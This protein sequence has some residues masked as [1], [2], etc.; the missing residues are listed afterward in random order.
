AIFLEFTMLALLAVTLFYT[1]EEERMDKMLKKMEDANRSQLDIL[2]GQQADIHQLSN[3]LVGQTSDIIKNRV[4][5]AISEYM[6]SDDQIKQVVAQ[7]IA[8]KILLGMRDTSSSGGSH[9]ARRR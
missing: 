4:E 9:G 2:K 1:E 7:E 6:T 8:D 5:N 3:A